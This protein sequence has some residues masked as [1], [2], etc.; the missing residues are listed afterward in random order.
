MG[1]T[2]Q[3]S[4]QYWESPRGSLSLQHIL[5]ISQSCARGLGC[6]ASAPVYTAHDSNWLRGR[7]F[8]RFAGVPSSEIENQLGPV[9]SSLSLFPERC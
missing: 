6:Q 7:Y 3:A 1:K 9:E 8:G 2:Y 5:S 4:S